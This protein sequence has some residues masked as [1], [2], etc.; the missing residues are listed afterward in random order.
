MITRREFVERAALAS[1]GAAALPLAGRLGRADRAPA[2]PG[3]AR[4]AA[5]GDELSLANDDVAAA[6]STAGGVLRAVRLEDRRNRTTLAPSP[7]VFVLALAGGTEVRS[8]A[9]RVAGP[10]R[11]ERLAG[12][13]AASRLVERSGGQQVS[14]A[15]ADASSPLRVTWRA[16]LRDGSAYLRQEI[17]LETAGAEL[18]VLRIALVDLA[19]PGVEV[20]GA[21]TGSPLVA[22]NLFLGFEHPLAGA[23]SDGGRARA[24]LDRALPLRPG[25]APAYSSVVGVTTPGQLRRDFLAY[26]ERERA[27]PYRTFLHYNS[28]YDLGYFN[29]YDQAGALAVIDAFG[30]ELE[31]RRGVALDSFLF[32]D[33]WDDH[34]TLWHFNAGFPDGFAPVR[35]ATAKYGAAPGVWMSPWGGY[36]QPR[37]E[38]LRY[39]RAQGFETDEGGFAL[40]GPRYYARFRDV[41]LDMI[42]TY[43]INQFKFDGT[44]NAATAIP[45]SEFDS[46]FDA[47]IHLIGEL[48]TV[49]PDLYVNLT[50]GTFPSPFWLRYADSIWRGG[51]DHDFA[52]VGTD[53]QQ[54]ITYRDADTYRGIVRQGPL[55]PLNSLMLH[56]LVYA[57]HAN[58][59]MTDPGGDFTSEI[60]AYFGTGTQLQEMYVTPALL[61][62][63]NWD[64]LAETARWARAR[65]PTLVD[66]HWVGG[67][68]GALQVYGHAAWG[69][70]RGILVLRNPKDESQSIE[71]DVGQA[72]EL[73]AR[74]PQNFTARSPWRSERH[75]PPVRL[76]VGTPH[77][78]SLR[79]FEVRTLEAVP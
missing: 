61:T 7:D 22:G 39:G 44:G 69:A 51:E 17:R 8:S 28:W 11:V 18:P 23:A 4:L 76:V 20:R 66:S 37:Q 59:L 9:M 73:P 13:P 34:Q 10:P 63:E 35:A 5:Q 6:W 33:G 47:A 57:R 49:K 25:T 46:D 65:A 54:W 38:R 16:V 56:G 78:F 74:A 50:T 62:A 64:T 41:C 58:R 77:T 75:D 19:I 60:R 14:V 36:G 42:R 24:W 26:L 29:A 53:R 79:P 55:F 48:R 43:G 2:G 30:T 45:G 67:D 21:V 31:V 68:P 71:L 15:L 12:D 72:L 40:S 70:G 3:A 32:D 1:A 52:G 27:H